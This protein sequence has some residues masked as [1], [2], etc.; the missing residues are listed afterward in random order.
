M[1][2]EWEVLFKLL[3]AL[4]LGGLVGYERERAHRPAGLRTN[5]LVCVGSTL[6]VLLESFY[7]DTH[8]GVSDHLRMASQVVTGIGFLGAGTIIQTRSAVRGLTT[9]ATIWVTAAV[10]MAI[11]VGFYSA[12]LIVVIVEVLSLRLLKKLETSLAMKGGRMLMINGE[13]KG[14]FARKLSEVLGELNVSVLDIR[15]SISRNR[16]METTVRIPAHVDLDLLVER[17]IKIE[18]VQRVSTE[19]LQE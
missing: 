19:L 11:G 12:S 14:D 13:S 18:G 9:A 5:I 15:L 1:V 17:V 7:H 2:I 8:T 10:G 6:V 3:L 4:V 16:A